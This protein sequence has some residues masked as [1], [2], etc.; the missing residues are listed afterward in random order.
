LGGELRL[1]LPV[2]RQPARMIFS[3]NPLRLNTVLHSPASVLQL[4]EPKTS[5]RFALGSFF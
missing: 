1:Q 2:I 5:L 3:W 4:T